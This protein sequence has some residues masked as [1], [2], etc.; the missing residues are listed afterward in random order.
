MKVF[1]IILLLNFLSLEAFADS[2][3]VE[4]EE[5]DYSSELTSSSKSLGFGMEIMPTP[6]KS[7]GGIGVFYRANDQWSF[8]LNAGSYGGNFD[9]DKGYLIAAARYYLPF[10]TYV[11]FGVGT[12]QNRA[13]FE[14]EKD[15]D[16]RNYGP[17]LEF[18]WSLYEDEEISI[19]LNIAAASISLNGIRKPFFFTNGIELIYY[20]L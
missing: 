15:E 16:F 19:G 7:T 3:K 20:F 18:G 13:G 5:Q 2:E 9:F 4:L 10:T 8:K 11:D 17:V 12:W 1:Y 14:T 6:F